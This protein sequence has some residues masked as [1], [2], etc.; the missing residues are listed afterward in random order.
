L[1]ATLW[2]L[3]REVGASVLSPA[4]F[5]GF[6]SSCASLVTD[7]GFRCLSFSRPV[8]FF[9]VGERSGEAFFG[10]PGPVPNLFSRSAYMRSFPVNET[11]LVHEVSPRRWRADVTF[12]WLT[13]AVPPV[14]VAVSLWLFPGCILFPRRFGCLSFFLSRPL[15]HDAHSCF[16]ISCSD[17][18]PSIP[19]SLVP[20]DCDAGPVPG[21]AVIVPLDLRPLRNR[22][23]LFL[24]VPL[25]HGQARFLQGRAMTLEKHLLL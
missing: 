24:F 25:V 3:R 8:R 9:S 18:P 1:I 13:C 15:G 16:S 21:P 11:W 2:S 17:T 10:A 5:I 19:H 4:F 20:G 14:R 12:R 7:F 22:I 23:R 6:L